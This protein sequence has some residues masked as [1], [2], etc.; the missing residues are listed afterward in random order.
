MVAIALSIL[1]SELASPAFADRILTFSKSPTW[2]NFSAG[3]SL[4]EKVK[5]TEEAPWG[6]NTDFEK[7]MDLI[8]NVA[9][10][11]KLLPSDIPDLIV[12]SDMQFDEA[13]QADGTEWETAHER[14]VRKFAEVGVEVCGTPWKPPHITFWNLRGDT[15]GFPAQQETQGVTMLSG[16]SPSLLQLLLSG[17]DVDDN[18]TISE[19][20]NEDGDVVLVKEKATKTPYQTV[21]KCLDNQEYDKIREVLGRSKEGSLAGYTFEPS[22]CDHESDK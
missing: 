2:I 11:A 1:V 9:V 16:F 14:I 6:C 21:R 20:I 10:S 19:I 17:E 8:L 22:A 18:E 4:A 3:L 5:A 15:I 7:A 12:F 13:S